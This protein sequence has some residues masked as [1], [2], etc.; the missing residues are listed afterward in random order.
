MRCYNR[1]PLLTSFHSCKREVRQHRNWCVANMLPKQLEKRSCCCDIFFNV[2][3]VLLFSN[4]KTK[5][6]TGLSWKS[7]WR[8]FS[9]KSDSKFRKLKFTSTMIEQICVDF[10]ST[11]VTPNFTGEM[12]ASSQYKTQTFK[13]FTPILAQLAFP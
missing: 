6:C 11:N 3:S 1:N 5:Q 9:Q 10:L 7:R 8:G 4:K 12:Q 2:A 13:N